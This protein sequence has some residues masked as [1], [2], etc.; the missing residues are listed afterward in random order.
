MEFTQA[1]HIDTV[2]SRQY[3][4]AIKG[5]GIYC[6]IRAAMDLHNEF[7]GIEITGK[8]GTQKDLLSAIGEGDRVYFENVRRRRE[9][10]WED[11]DGEYDV[12]ESYVLVDASKKKMFSL[13]EVRFFSEYAY[14]I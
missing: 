2:G 11:Y 14:V 4:I 13:D 9:G 12:I 6:G 5:T 8:K 7:Y 1:W 10:S 3:F